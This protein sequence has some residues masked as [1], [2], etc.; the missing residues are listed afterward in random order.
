[1][2]DTIQVVPNMTA[3]L[4]V[5]AG[6]GPTL[7]NNPGPNT[8]FL[9]D[10]D[11]IRYTDASGIV[12][13][14]AN[15]F[16][17]VDGSSDLFATIAP[18][19]V[20][21][22]NVISGGLN[23]F[24]P[25]SLSGLGGAK[26]FV[27]ATAPTQPPT[28]PLNSLWFNT[29]ANAMEYWNGA[30]WTIQAFSAAQ[31]LQAA[32]ITATQVQNGTLTTTQLAAAAGILGTQIANATIAGAN[33][34]ANTITAA[35]IAANT[36]TVSQLA[37]GIVYAGIVDGTLIQGATLRIKNGSGATIMTVNI[38]AGT[39]LQYLDTGSSTQGYLI[40]SSA[41]SAITDEFS[42]SVLAGIVNYSKISSSSFLATQLIAGNVNFLNAS[43]AAGP[44]NV[45]SSLQP[46]TTTGLL[47]YFDNQGNA[48]TFGVASK[49]NTS[50]QTISST[51]P[52]VI[53]LNQAFSWNVESGLT[54]HLKLFLV[55]T[56]AGAVGT[57]SVGFD[58]SST[59]SSV[60][61]FAEWYGGGMVFQTGS[62]IL[63]T[64]SAIVGPTLNTGNNGLIVE[65]WFTC[66]ATGTFNVRA[67][68]GVS[69]DAWS[70]KGSAAALE[71][72]GG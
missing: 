15:G 60:N 21:T 53:G 71:V 6:D 42:N 66:T 4:I 44:W 9:G 18:G 34:A 43:S 20:Q 45:Y 62:F 37:A 50:L 40:S 10:N 69:G 17:N 2:T 38:S 5:A 1:M 12:A 24:S 55:Y 47:S 65:A 22:L 32:T 7:V 3:T 59:T 28:I 36:I 49:Y 26:V 67:Q 54:Y 51:T 57:P 31:L 56:G 8:I 33:I 68:E 48:F 13:L 70:I 61:G 19:Q 63:G 29:T 23:F 58:G 41:L 52:V 39:W 72:V 14:N 25:P 11:A 16:I 35:N 30:A 27:Q 64:F 46:N